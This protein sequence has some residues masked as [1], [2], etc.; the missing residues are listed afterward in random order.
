MNN[1]RT[2]ALA[3]SAVALSFLAMRGDDASVRFDAF[4]VSPVVTL[5]LP[6]V[7]ADSTLSARNAFGNEML[8]GAVNSRLVK[9]ADD[10]TS[11]NAD[12]ASVVKFPK[13]ALN[14][15]L[16]TVATRMRPSR[17]VSG[18]I[19]LKSNVIAE[20]KNGTSTLVSFARPD[21]VATWQE[22]SFCLEPQETADLFVTFVSRPDDPAAPEISLEFVP[23][24]GFSGVDYAVGSDITKRFRIENSALGTRLYSTSISPD[25][26]YVMLN[27]MTMYGEG[28]S[29]YW[30]ELQECASGKTISASLPY[31]SHWTDRGSTLYYTVQ[32]DDTYSLYTMDAATQKQTLLASDLPQN[33]FS[34]SP[35]GSYLLFHKFVEGTKD[36]GPLL[37]LQDPDDRLAGHRDRYYLEKYDLAT[38]VTQPLT[39]S[40]NTTSVYDISPDSKKLVYVSTDERPDTYPFYFQNII[41]LDVNTLATD[42][43]VKDE[44]Y[45]RGCQYSPDGKQLFIMAGAEAFKGIGKDNKD[46]KYS[47]DYDIQGFIMN[48]AD[49]AVRPVTVDFNPSLE[50]GA[51]WNRADGKIYF[52]ASD[53]FDLNVYSLDPG[54]GAISRIDFGM[55]YVSG[56]SIGS[57]ETKWISATGGDFSYTGRAELKELKS[58]KTRI[59]DDP[60]SRDY[61][62]TQ[63]GEASRWTFTASDGTVIDCQQVLPPDFDPS[64]KYPMIVYYYGGCSPTQKYVSVYDPQIFASRGYVT[65]VMNPS[66]AYGYGQDFAARHANAWGDRTADDIIEGV[67]E[68]CRTRGFVDDKKIGCL[69]AS[70]GG[71]R[72]SISRLRPTS[73]RRRCHMP[74]SPM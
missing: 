26:K 56:F 36:Q 25:G 9:V 64:V 18:K 71:F 27:Y 51:V 15:E 68:Y 8:L 48:I 16:R 44:P 28:R 63:A 1:I 72:P 41:Q 55:P 3:A 13:A 12:T 11:E 61:P 38:G 67:K 39:Y 7:P 50:D 62:D 69:G 59:V 45:F 31:G 73:S 52:R 17:Y 60:Y 32:T 43:L 57:D 66:G 35:D 19:R 24:F 30:S 37:R 29:R 70:Y 23:D 20:L 6:A 14:S 10:W 74:E 22:A 42:T 58:G 54:N 49:R 21:S 34:I 33:N 65:L 47:N 5:R 46:R 40:G 53:G 2:A 4:R